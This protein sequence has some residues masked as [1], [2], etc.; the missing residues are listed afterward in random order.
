M[1]IFLFRALFVDT[2]PSY[3]VAEER[4]YFLLEDTPDIFFC[5]NQVSFCHSTI[6]CSIIYHTS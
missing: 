1:S 3:P 2:L 6:V 4:D 5:G